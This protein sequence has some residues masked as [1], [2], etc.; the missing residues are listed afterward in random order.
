MPLGCWPGAPC[1]HPCSPCSHRFG[2]DTESWPVAS[3][4]TLGPSSLTPSVHPLF[5][6]SGLLALPLVLTCLSTSSVSLSCHC[7]LSPFFPS[8]GQ[9]FLNLPY[10]SHSSSTWDCL[11]V[12]SP[13]ASQFPFFDPFCP[14]SPRG[15]PLGTSHRLLN[16][17]SCGSWAPSL[18]AAFLLLFCDL[19]ALPALHPLNIEASRVVPWF[20]EGWELSYPRAVSSCPVATPTPKKVTTPRSPVPMLSWGSSVCLSYHTMPE[21]EQKFCPSIMESFSSFPK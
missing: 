15:L 2:R 13:M 16:V 5:S 17:S 14:W 20:S 7:S 21:M 6:I 1:T 8:P 3:I 11:S 18:L 4:Q 19:C 9:H 10:E 12:R